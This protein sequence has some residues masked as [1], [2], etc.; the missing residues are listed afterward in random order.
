MSALRKTLRR[1]RMMRRALFI[2]VLAIV[3]LVTGKAVLDRLDANQL[4]TGEIVGWGATGEEKRG[5]FDRLA[6]DAPPAPVAITRADQEP[7]AP[8]SLAKVAPDLWLFVNYRD[9]Y[10][11][12]PV[13]RIAHPV[14]PPR[15]VEVWN[16]SGI[17][18]SP[19]YDRLFIANYTG[20]DVLIA[21]IER[22]GDQVSLLLDARLTHLEGIKGPEGIHVSPGGRFMAVADYL[23]NAVSLFE[24]VDG[25]WMFRWKQTL[26][27]SH[28]VSIVGGHVYAG[29]NSIAKFEVETGKEINRVSTI[30]GRAILFATCINRDEQSGGLIGSDP[31]AGRVFTM[32]RDLRLKDEFGAN[33]PGRVNFSMPYCVYRDKESLTILST[34][35]DRILDFKSDANKS[36]EFGDRRW[37]YLS[38]PMPH[39]AQMW[40]GVVRVDGPSHKILGLELRASYGSLIAP[41]G[42]RLDLP[43]RN[44]IFSS[45]WPFYVTSIAR[46]GD[47]FA[48]VSNST[49][50]VLLYQR[51]T[52]VLGWSKTQEWDCWANDHEVL[53][54]RRRYAIADLVAHSRIASSAKD[55]EA[56]SESLGTTRSRLLDEFTSIQGKALRD[57]I[58]QKSN[59]EAAVLRYLAAAKGRPV[60]LV[61]YWL[62]TRLSETPLSPK[63]EEG[64]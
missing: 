51:S 17:Y 6:L 61:E 16:P 15:A 3:V 29:G 38:R 21:A 54:P 2:T 57:A 42:T 48:I 39:S 7:L 50:A 14:K 35:Q 59:V 46:Q 9:V 26:P 31:M 10:A 44:S 8:V 43:D 30:G 56:I 33:G 41:D 62:A 45:K 5:E 18:Y 40:H 58:D 1:E 55:M 32:T 36:Y 23:G 52:G 4:K 11:F 34:Y 60:P 27:A 53:C 13:K 28:G 63:R 49:P 64:K 19:Y 37:A 22:N 12:D 25:Q 20:K 24:R 47:W